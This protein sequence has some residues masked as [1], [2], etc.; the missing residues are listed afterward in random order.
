LVDAT[1]MAV[2]VALGYELMSL[3]LRV[4]KRASSTARG[5]AAILWA[6]ASRDFLQPKS[7][8]NGLRGARARSPQTGMTLL[9]LIISCSILLVLASAALP[10]AR[11][12]IWHQKERQLRYN[13]QMI[14]DAID[15]FNDAAIHQQIRTDP[16]TQ[17]Y[18]PDLETLVK[19]VPLG[20][21]GDKTLRFLRKIPV[22]PMTGKADW[23]LRGVGDDPDS[24]HWSGKNVFDI[25]SNSS[26]T[27]IDGTRYSE[28]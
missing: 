1:L 5:R 4:P 21:S 16:S 15:A 26:A 8:R 13:L 9:E 3:A 2:L 22:D 19:G 20:T 14:R 12:T 6:G 27:A 28:W 11:Y 7:A 10:I 24:T 25:Y 18:P 23:D 17:N